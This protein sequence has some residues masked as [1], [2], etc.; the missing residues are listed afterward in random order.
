MF[1]YSRRRAAGLRLM[2]LLL[3]AGAAQ[4]QTTAPV[5][6]TTP[7]PAAVTALEYFIDTDP[8]LG[9]GVAVPVTAAPDVT[10]TFA[11]SL[12]GLQPGVHRL[13]FRALDA[14]GQWSLTTPQLFYLAPVLHLPTPVAADVTALEYFF[15]ADPG[16][17]NGA[18]LP[19]TAGP[20]VTATVAAAT[21]ALSTGVHYL[22]IRARNSAG[23][24]SLTN[25]KPVYVLPTIS[26][27]PHAT[28]SP[29]VRAEYFVDM[30]PGLGQAPGIPV[31]S[32]TDVTISNFL[33]SLGG[34][35]SGVHKI[36]LRFQD[37]AGN[38]SLTNQEKL[39]VVAVNL[40]LP[41]AVP[42]QPFTTLEYFF[43]TDPGMGNG[44]LVTVPATTDLQSHSL[45]ADISALATGLHVLYVRTLSD[46]S[47]TAS[48][49]FRIGS[50]LPVK[51]IHF[52]G[53]MEAQSVVLSW[54][55]GTEEGNAGFV[56]ERSADARIFDSL[57]FV[58]AR[59]ATAGHYAFKDDQPLEGASYYRLR[60]LD[61]NGTTTYSHT[62]MMRIAAA[63]KGASLLTNNPVGDQLKVFGAAGSAGE[64]AFSVWN[65]QG[66]ETARFQGSGGPVE[67]FNISG[68]PAGI[69]LL[70]AQKG[71]QVQ[72]VRFRKN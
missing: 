54:E 72:T 32:G 17:G 61:L 29:I 27:P 42:A 11:A 25:V 48:Q 64:I 39:T 53:K 31:A 55:T 46:R 56:V 36:G 44:T 58:A 52:S 65:M 22:G 33:L 34:L 15:D 63:E 23:Q 2:G 59:K 8:G 69:Y 19:V 43:D 70:R 40:S 14:Q 60:Q 24:W 35:S 13:Y 38:W 47:L 30:D 67:T 18:P 7:P 28:A 6:P 21:S 20:D 1:A 41:P 66:Q 5:P 50:P 10:Q 9:N 3:L 62:L 51:L 16:F 12:N 37:A 57:G 49:G 45:V 26:L 4:A 71:G 68:I